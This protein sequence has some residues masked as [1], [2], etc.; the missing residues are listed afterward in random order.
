MPSNE[1][2]DA[3]LRSVRIDGLD[4]VEGMGRFN[5]SAAIYM[6]IVA[7]F[8]KSTPSTLAELADVDQA[9]LA[10]YAVRVHGLK[11]SCYGISANACGDAAKALEMMAK[12]EDLAGVLA[13]NGALIQMVQ[14]LIEDLKGLVQRVEQSDGTDINSQVRDRPDPSKLRQL[15]DATSAYD[16]MEMQSIIDEL[17]AFDYV[18]DVDLVPW[19]KDRI[20]SFAYD[21]VKER[22]RSI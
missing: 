14:E 17:S 10:D 8:I 2:I 18:N 4:P 1:Q 9:T 19:L 15:R 7:A 13:G 12:A 6:R 21:E 3:I 5:G 16:I 20:D 22:L 11:G